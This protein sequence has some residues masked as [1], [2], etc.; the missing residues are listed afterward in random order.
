LACLVAYILFFVSVD[1]ISWQ[2]S[3]CTLWVYGSNCINL[4]TWKKGRFTSSCPATVKVDFSKQVPGEPQY[5]CQ[6]IWC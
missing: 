1:C 4:E 2:S 3:V 5:S 6:E